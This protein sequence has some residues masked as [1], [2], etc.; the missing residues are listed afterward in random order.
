MY[1]VWRGLNISDTAVSSP[2]IQQ[3]VGTHML[4]GLGTLTFAA[5]VHAIS[6]TYFMGTGRWVEETSRAYK[7]PTDFHDENQKIKYRLMPG[8]T[9]IDD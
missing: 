4:I 9:Q 8:S 1:A 7:L 6:L 2:E 5:L 3:Q